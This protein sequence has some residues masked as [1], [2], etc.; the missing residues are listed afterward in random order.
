MRKLLLCLVLATCLAWS[1]E[2][3][4]DELAGCRLP[5]KGL[6]SD[7]GLGF[8]RNTNR[9]PSVGEVHLTV[10]FADFPDLP[11]TMTPEQALALISP[12]AETFFTVTSYGKLKL[13]LDPYLHWTRMSKPSADFG[14]HRGSGFDVH[15]AY[16]QEAIDLTPEAD[17]SR[18]QGVV[19]IANPAV[20]AIDYG[21]AFTASP[22]F[23]VQ[24]GGREILNGATSGSDLTYWGWVWF[25]HEIGH[26]LSLIDLAGPAPEN[27]HWN[28]YVGDF[29]VMGNVSGIGREYLGWER[30]QLGW[31]DDSQV[32]CAGAADLE[33]ALTPIEEPRGA[34]IVVVPLGETRAVIVESRHAEWFDRQ[35]PR[36]G[37]LVYVVD[38]AIGTHDGAIRIV[39][40]S[41]NED[42]YLSSLL[43]EGRSVEIEGVTVTALGDDRLHVARLT[44]PP[45]TADT[46]P[47]PAAGAAPH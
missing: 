38:T 37:L 29:S 17:Y 1:G 33:A 18:A 7:V 13:V 28:T 39:P 43:T 27:G 26:A 42:H 23:G 10:L 35:L 36:S 44:L 15:R 22:G 21:P 34:K 8:P 12:H 14:F 32:I 20:K 11:A 2:A 45:R 41:P 4:A 30:W 25:N 3:P 47:D 46:S 9:L 19:V 6:R 16:L 5:E 31:L 40:H 24:A